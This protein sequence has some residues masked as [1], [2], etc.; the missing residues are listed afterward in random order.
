MCWGREAL[1]HLVGFCAAPSPLRVLVPVATLLLGFRYWG[2]RRGAQL[3]AA[4]PPRGSCKLN[5]S[6]R[7]SCWLLRIQRLV[8]REARPPA[9]C[10]AVRVTTCSCSTWACPAPARS[11]APAPP[12][13]TSHTAPGESGHACVS[14][15]EK[16]PVEPRVT[17]VPSDA[18]LLVLCMARM[19]TDGTAVSWRFSAA[20]A[21][22][23]A[24]VGL[25]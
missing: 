18:Q 15:I 22:C 6:P 20:G 16:W 9:F 10:P 13:A 7:L 2:A 25:S 1:G 17:S 23:G 12:P 5:G 21:P 3:A 19:V 4:T 24:W 14:P 8:L 11:P